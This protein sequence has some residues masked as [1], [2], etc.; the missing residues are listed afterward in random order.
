MEK[1]IL[2]TYNNTHL[3]QKPFLFF[4]IL[5]TPLTLS[6]NS[7]PFPSSMTTTRHTPIQTLAEIPIGTLKSTT[8]ICCN[9]STCL[10][11][12]N[13]TID[14]PTEIHQKHTK[15]PGPFF[16]NWQVKDG[17]SNSVFPKPSKTV[18]TTDTIPQS[19]LDEK[20]SEH[21]RHQRR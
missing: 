18:S 20:K 4:E 8:R 14:Q 19:P 15:K 3:Y 16:E 9:S 1:A 5:I 10:L 17:R 11:I 2:I 7:G 21:P 6:P 13:S 12:V